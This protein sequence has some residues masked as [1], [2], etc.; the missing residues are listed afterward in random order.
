VRKTKESPKETLPCG[1]LLI[2]NE[3]F[4]YIADTKT[5]QNQDFATHSKLEV[6]PKSN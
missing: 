2:C 4:T 3:D 1:A 6:Q 5:Q